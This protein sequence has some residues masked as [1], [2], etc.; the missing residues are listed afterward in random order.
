M[1]EH[2]DG[3]TT[4]V[5]TYMTSRRKIGYTKGPRFSSAQETS[6]PTGDP[7]THETSI[8]SNDRDEH[9]NDHGIC[10][11]ERDHGSIA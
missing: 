3:N 9:R 1:S 8:S 10:H 4:R 6:D 11:A 2:V 7:Q 5:K